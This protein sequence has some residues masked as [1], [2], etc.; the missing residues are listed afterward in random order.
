MFKSVIRAYQ[1]PNRTGIGFMPDFINVGGTALIRAKPKVEIRFL[2]GQIIKRVFIGDTPNS[3][4]GSFITMFF[5][6]DEVAVMRI[7]ASPVLPGQKAVNNFAVFRGMPP[8]S[9]R[10]VTI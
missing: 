5:R 6:E 7:E 9:T 8:E 4:Y 2:L 10:I 3:P 1:L